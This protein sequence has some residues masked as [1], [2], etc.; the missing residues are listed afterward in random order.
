MGVSVSGGVL[1]YRFAPDGS[2]RFDAVKTAITMFAGATGVGTI[3]LTLRTHFTGETDRINNQFDAAASKL[4]DPSSVTQTVGLIALQRLG[5]RHPA[6]RAAVVGILDGYMYSFGSPHVDLQGNISTE[7]NEVTPR[8][9]L[10]NRIV[11]EF[12]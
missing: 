10:A 2:A 6:Y 1:L 3:V 5:R 4:T 11:A 9:V 7:Y 8:Q 12:E